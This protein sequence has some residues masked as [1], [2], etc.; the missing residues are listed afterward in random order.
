MKERNAT[1]MLQRKPTEILRKAVLGMLSRNR[2]RHKYIEPRLR[3]YEGPNH[4]HTAQL[5]PDIVK[6]MKPHPRKRMG[7]YHFGLEKGQYAPSGVAQ[8][9]IIYK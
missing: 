8:A 2:L 7:D 5:P 3:I 9:G 1:D 4:P 6:P